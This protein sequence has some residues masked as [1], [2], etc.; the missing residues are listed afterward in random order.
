M[1]HERAGPLMGSLERARLTPLA[2]DQVRPVQMGAF[3]ACPIRTRLNLLAVAD[4]KVL[5]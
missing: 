4:P 5:E 3:W 1:L 2:H